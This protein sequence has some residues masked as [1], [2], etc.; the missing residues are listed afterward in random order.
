MLIPSLRDVSVKYN[1]YNFKENM[2]KLSFFKLKKQENKSKL[3]KLK[4]F[5]SI[6]FGNSLL[7]KVIQPSDRRH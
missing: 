1:Q 3:S 4:C 5:V 2:S 6:S 7:N